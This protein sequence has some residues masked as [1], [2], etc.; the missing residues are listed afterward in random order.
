MSSGL[1]RCTFYSVLD[2]GEPQDESPRKSTTRKFGQDVLAKISKDEAAM[3]AFDEFSVEMIACLKD[4]FKST[5]TYRSCVRN[6]GSLSI[7][8]G[9][10]KSLTS[11]SLPRILL[12]LTNFSSNLLLS[13]YSRISF[14]AS[15]HENQHL[16]AKHQ[17]ILSEHRNLTW[18][19]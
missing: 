7:K 19:R 17:L 12:I 8:Y 3:T 6:C 5:K 15:F 18:R 2:T 13:N 10:P 9:S 4:I 16:P 14:Y 11:F 1:V